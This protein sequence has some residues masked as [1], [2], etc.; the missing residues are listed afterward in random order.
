DEVLCEPR[1]ELALD[2]AVQDRHAAEG[3]D[4]IRGQRALPRLFD[5]LR[6][7]DAARIGVLDDHRR[8]LVELARDAARALEIGEVV[9]RELLPPEL[10][11]AREKVAPSRRLD[12]E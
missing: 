7:R 3:R 10:L 5:G 8:R 6:D 11:D 9:E 12:V 4:R 1:A 2:R